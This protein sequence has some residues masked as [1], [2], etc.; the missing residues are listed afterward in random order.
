MQI[1]L[2][3]R[4]LSYLDLF[5]S[6]DPLVGP[7]DLKE[8]LLTVFGVPY[9]GTTSYRP[10][11]RFGPNAIREAFLNVEAYSRRLGVDVERLPM[12]DAG[13]LAKRSDPEAMVEAVSKVT[14]ELFTKGER[15]C[16]LGGEHT[17]TGGSFVNAPK[18]TV[19][20]VFDAHFDLRD[21]WEG[22]KLSHACYLRRVTEKADPSVVAHIG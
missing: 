4:Q 6:V 10:G 16:M 15:F 5:S 1:R 11:T 19:L 7:K 8:P 21:E 13:N 17:L 9:D 2:G 3:E 14:K 22:S 12:R 20:V 18:R